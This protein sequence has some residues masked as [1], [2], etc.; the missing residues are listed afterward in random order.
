TVQPVGA[1][2]LYMVD[3]RERAV[4]FVRN[5]QTYPRCG[6]A[7]RV[8]WCLAALVLIGC[9]DAPAET[10]GATANLGTSG[11]RLKLAW[12]ETPDGQRVIARYEETLFSN[13]VAVA[14]YY[15]T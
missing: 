7:R 11:T 2:V 6:Y 12:R 5:T 10:G 3:E 15:D 14:D 4:R 1:Q 9:S 8:R 13:P